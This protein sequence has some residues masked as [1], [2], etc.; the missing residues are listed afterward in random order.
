M[1]EFLET[2]LNKVNSENSHL[3][4]VLLSWWRY[5]QTVKLMVIV[6]EK[7]SFDTI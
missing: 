1:K 4:Q 2:A 5:I 3:N 6:E 7:S